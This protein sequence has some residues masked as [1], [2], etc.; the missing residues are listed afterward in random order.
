MAVRDI[1]LWPFRQLA[2]VPR[3]LWS[4]VGSLE[5]GKWLR[6]YFLKPIINTWIVIK[7]VGGWV[8]GLGTPAQQIIGS[9]VAAFAIILGSLGVLTPVVVVLIPF[10]TIGVLRLLPFVDGQ[11]QRF[12]GVGDDSYQGDL[13]SE[14]S[15]FG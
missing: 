15:Y 5:A 13:G 11:W 3:R 4:G 9:V 6:F 10:W 14:V 8:L 2:A 12:T 7:L 1:V